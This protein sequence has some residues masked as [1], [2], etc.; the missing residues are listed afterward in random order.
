MGRDFIIA[1][2]EEN[3]GWFAV[4]LSIVVTLARGSGAARRAGV[5]LLFYKPQLGATSPR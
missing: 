1:R 5:R 4:L 2:T 3:H